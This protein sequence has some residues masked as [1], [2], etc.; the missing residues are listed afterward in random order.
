MR[1]RLAAVVGAAALCAAAAVGLRAAAA[2]APTPKD[3]LGAAEAAKAHAAS[4]E[5]VSRIAFGSCLK[6]NRPQPIWDAVLAARPDVF[7]FLGD[8]VYADTSDMDELK[9]CYDRLAA[10]PG[11]Q[12]LR[13][14]CSV[15]ATWDDHDYCKNGSDGSFRGKRDSQRI[16]ADFWGDGPDSP[17][18]GRDGVYDVVTFGPEGQRVQIILLDARFFRSQRRGTM[19]GE[20]Q[21]SWLEG[22]L[23]EEADVRIIAS[24]SQFVASHHA[25][26]KWADIPSERSRMIELINKT[27]ASGVVF[28]S[29]DRHHAEISR[30]TASRPRPLAETGL[31]WDPSRDAQSAAAESASAQPKY[32]IYDVTS[33]SL[34][35]SKWFVMEANPHRLGKTFPK[36]NFGLIEIDWSRPDPVISMQVRDVEGKT[37]ISHEVRLSELR[38]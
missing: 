9:S 22:R 18:R 32:P 20:A 26:D 34:N 4:G 31:P 14:A 7:V 16:F 17:R 11:F 25:A 29:G 13:Q 33:S 23:R 36:S 8:N 37:R 28:I 2:P 6:Q 21:W 24:C 27:G 1:T 12:A 15:I 38:G 19:L 10:Q 35:R 3:A 30:L 5:V